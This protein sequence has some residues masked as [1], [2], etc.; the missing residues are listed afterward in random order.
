MNKCIIPTMWT[1]QSDYTSLMLCTSVTLFRRQVMQPVINMLEEDRGT[2]INNIHK[3]FGKNHACGSGDILADR[4]TDTDRHTH[5]N[6]SQLLP[7]AT[8]K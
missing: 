2:D 5:H 6:T 4:Q 3:K 7:W 8:Y 1:R